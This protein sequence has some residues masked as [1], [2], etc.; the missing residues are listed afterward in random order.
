MVRIRSKSATKQ[1]T[2][3]DTQEKK[4]SLST[5]NVAIPDIDGEGYAKSKATNFQ[6]SV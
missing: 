5:P 6:G 2:G 3:T 4:R 1:N